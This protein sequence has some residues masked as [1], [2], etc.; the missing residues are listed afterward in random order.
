MAGPTGAPTI[1]LA[2][3]MRM[4]PRELMLTSPVEVVPGA[5]SYLNVPFA[6][7]PGFRLHRLDL[8]VPVSPR[9]GAPLVTYASGGAWLMS[10]KA[11]G[12]WRFLLQEGY[13]VAAVEYRV[14]G[15]ARHPA[16]IHDL[17]AAVRWL[18][19][20]AGEYGLDA[21]NIVA[22]GS[23]AGGYLSSM[24]AVTNG[25]PEFEGT[26]GDHLD[27]SSEVMAVIDH[28]GAIDLAKM[29]EDTNSIPGVLEQFGTETSPETK[30]LGYRPQDNP[31]QAELANPAHY[32][33]ADTVP[34]LI[35]HGDADT[36]LGIGQS[37][38]FY[39]QLCEA[40]VKA[41]F[42]VVPGANHGTP[43]FDSPQAHQL[44]LD[45]LASLDFSGRGGND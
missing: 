10:L 32:L 12:P 19:A 37:E 8:H 2:T 36:R 13:A 6:L 21:V 1:S 29:G 38:R 45:F 23:S 40:G 15:E 11:L 18:R 24:C 22:W 14:S 35:V 42:H 30:L 16:G 33:S 43:E 41:Q 34:F 7:V 25:R 9:P 4:L 26:V 5:R 27:Q 44:A 39:R 17:K 20:N 28:Y 3:A 31:A